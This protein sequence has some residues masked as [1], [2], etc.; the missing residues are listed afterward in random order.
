MRTDVFEVEPGT[1]TDATELPDLA[2]IATR[3]DLHLVYALVGES[4]AYYREHFEPVLGGVTLLVR[5]PRVVYERDKSGP[6]P[7]GEM[8]FRMRSKGRFTA[9]RHSAAEMLFW[10]GRN[11]NG[12]ELLGEVT[13]CRS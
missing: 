1:E 9:G 5:G 13:P 7:V 6:T 11:E 2:E 12:F 4:G 10:A 3:L 8:L